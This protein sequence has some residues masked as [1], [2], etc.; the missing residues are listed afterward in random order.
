MFALMLAP[1][2]VPT[3]EYAVS[4]A[5][6]CL[7]SGFGMEPGVPTSPW[8]PTKFRVAVRFGV[9]LHQTTVFAPV[10]YRKSTLP[11]QKTCLPC[12]TPNHSRYRQFVNHSKIHSQRGNSSF[13]GISEPL[14]VVYD[15]NQFS[16]T[17]NEV[18]FSFSEEGE[19][20]YAGSVS[21]H[22]RSM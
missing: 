22:T 19:A 14:R 9:I 20:F 11:S 17:S 4:S 16:P 1:A 5:M 12:L 18:Y 7:T 2:Y 13:I 3:H 21:K 15:L 6:R 8:E 10:K